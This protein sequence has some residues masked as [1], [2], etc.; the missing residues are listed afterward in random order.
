MFVLVLVLSANLHAQNNSVMH[1]FK[2]PGD[3]FL[4]IKYKLIAGESIPDKYELLYVVMEEDDTI[5]Y[6]EKYITK[7]TWSVTRYVVLNGKKKLSGWQRFFD[8]NGLL[9][10]EQFC[11]TG[12]TNC[13]QIVRY[14]WYP[15]GQL[16]ATGNYYK[17]KP[18]GSYYYYYSNG[19]L[20]QHALYEKGKFMEVL[21]YYDQDGNPLYAG[22][23]CDGEGIANVY[24]VSGKLIQIKSFVHGEVKKTVTIGD[25]TH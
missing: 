24:S 2:L 23:L 1:N 25:E 13:K 7:K 16:L 8:R 9:D 10:Y 14:G 5:Q 17:S 22:T 20:R 21:A 6:L 12:K 3:N 19:Q 4:H 18:H 15:G 11:E